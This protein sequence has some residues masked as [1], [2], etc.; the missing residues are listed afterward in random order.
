M[1]IDACGRRR[2]GTWQGVRPAGWQHGHGVWGCGLRGMCSGVTRELHH[3]PRVW[4]R[5]A[6]GPDAEDG[7]RYAGHGVAD[8]PARAL[9][10]PT[11]SILF[12][13]RHFEIPKLLKF[14]LHSKTYE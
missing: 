9:W 8:T 1:V 12:E 7:R 5:V 14:E 11:G 4:G 13:L 6:G 10:R 2:R 3:E